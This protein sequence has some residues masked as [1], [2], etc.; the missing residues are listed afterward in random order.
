[1][2]R[3]TTEGSLVV[4]SERGTRPPLVLIHPTGGHLT[5]YRW[6]Q[7]LLAAEEDQPLYAVRSRASL[8]PESEHSSIES[9]AVDY[10]GIV[11]SIPSS[12]AGRCRLFGW[13]MGGLIAHAIACELERDGRAVD[14]VGMADPLSGGG[15]ESAEALD[16]RS[17]SVWMTVHAFHP[18]RLDPRRVMRAIPTLEPATFDDPARLVAWIEEKELLPKGAAP[19]PEQCARLM[20][21][22]AKHRRLVLAHRPGRCRAPLTIWRADNL[23]RREPYDWSVHT[24]GGVTERSAKGTHFSMMRPPHVDVIGTD[25]QALLQSKLEA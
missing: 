8:D 23:L 21:L 1:V 14:F 25:V 24:S 17:A 5:E 2:T 10:A 19:P 15:S 4:V 6:L 11:R 3:T 16:E 12:R 22:A 18:N 7:A 9:M 20:R 13:S